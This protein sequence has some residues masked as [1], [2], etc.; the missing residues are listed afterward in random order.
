MAIF[1]T[2]LC[3]C[4]A[5]FVLWPALFEREFVFWLA[6]LTRSSIGAQNLLVPVRSLASGTTRVGVAALSSA[7]LQQLEQRLRSSKNLVL[8]PK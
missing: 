7:G 1:A 5:L 6:S 2:A 8:R 4:S 3:N